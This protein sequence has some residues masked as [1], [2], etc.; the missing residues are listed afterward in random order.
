METIVCCSPRLARANERMAGLYQS[1][2][3]N[4][5]QTDNLELHPGAPPW[6][7]SVP[8]TASAPRPRAQEEGEPVFLFSLIS[9]S[10]ACCRA[11]KRSWRLCAPLCSPFGNSYFRSDLDDS[12]AALTRPRSRPSSG[13]PNRLGHATQR[14]PDRASRTRLW[15]SHRFIGHHFCCIA[16]GRAKRHVAL[17]GPRWLRFFIFIFSG[18]ACGWK[19]DAHI[20]ATSLH[21]RSASAEKETKEREEDAVAY[22][23]S[24]LPFCSRLFCPA[25]S[26]L[27]TDSLSLSLTLPARPVCATRNQPSRPANVSAGGA[28]GREAHPPGDSSL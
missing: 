28:A 10:R 3:G 8:T 6:P 7:M 27:G 20:T 22:L 25:S 16:A 1:P 14:R 15:P 26:C 19:Q 18:G 5:P 23:P 12:F 13:R 9:P 11:G 4:V 24:S 2:N 17:S 21:P